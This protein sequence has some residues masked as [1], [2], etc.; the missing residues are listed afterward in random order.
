MRGND[1]P[2]V[3]VTACARVWRKRGWRPET[4]CEGGLDEVRNSRG[5]LIG[6]RCRKCGAHHDE[7]RRLIKEPTE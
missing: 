3:D 7:Q 6:F 5:D 1:Q 4:R 2:V